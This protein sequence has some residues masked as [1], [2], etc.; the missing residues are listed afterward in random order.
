MMVKA[1]P[2]FEKYY[3]SRLILFDVL[4][5]PVLIFKVGFGLQRVMLNK[6]M[7]RC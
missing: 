6:K 2:L 5:S 3:T 4:M 7:I 1:D